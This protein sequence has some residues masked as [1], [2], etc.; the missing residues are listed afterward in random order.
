MATTEVDTELFDR[1]WE[2]AFENGEMDVVDEVVASDYV[3]HSAGD[4]EPVRGP[5]EFKEH[6]SQYRAAFP[7]FSVTIEDRIVADDAV[8]ERFRIRGTHE[9]E[10][11]GI[12][13]T[14]N[15]VELTGIVIH[16]IDD[17]KAV[18]DYS[19]FNGLDLM[20]QLGV[21]EGPGN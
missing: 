15:E 4:T 20:Q 9:G 3:L 16:Y 13:P 17:G 18:E 1:V 7:D 19:E 21:V 2:E 6:V 12:P 10:F 11:R 5:E 14:G 8:V